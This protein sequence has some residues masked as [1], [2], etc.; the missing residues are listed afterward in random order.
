[1]ILVAAI[2]CSIAQDVQLTSDRFTSP[3]LESKKEPKPNISLTA[4]AR[5][6]AAQSELGHTDSNVGIQKQLEGIA[7]SHSRLAEQ[8]IGLQADNQQRIEVLQAANQRLIWTLGAVGALSAL[9]LFLFIFLYFKY[10]YKAN[11]NKFKM[12]SVEK[13]DTLN[14]G[15]N[16]AMDQASGLRELFA[17]RLPENSNQSVPTPTPDSGE[18]TKPKTDFNPIQ[19][20]QPQRKA[21]SP[22][23][24]PSS[25]TWVSLVSSDLVSIEKTLKEAKHDFMRITP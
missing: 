12:A 23:S 22:E 25:G 20:Q 8:L 1:M 9:N 15:D 16:Q 11:A 7:L 21:S 19:P 2:S 17:F 6:I 24:S 4:R 3:L 10:I 13:A 18:V 14:L 5:P